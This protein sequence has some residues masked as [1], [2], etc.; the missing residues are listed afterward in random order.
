MAFVGAEEDAEKLAVV[1]TALPLP[2]LN[3]LSCAHTRAATLKVSSERSIVIWTDAVGVL[4]NVL[5][6]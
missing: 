6:A 1:V 4:L 5:S 2:L 3:V